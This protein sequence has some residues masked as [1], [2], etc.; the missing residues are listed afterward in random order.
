MKKSFTGPFWLL[1]G[2][3]LLLILA[4]SAYLRV[5]YGSGWNASGRSLLSTS[6]LL[7]VFMWPVIFVLEAL[8][9]WLIRQRNRYRALSW[10]HSAIFVLSFLLNIF[11]TWIRTMHYRLSSATERRIDSQIVMHEQMYFF[12]GLVILAHV[13]FVAVLANC[14]RK[15][16]PLV[17]VDPK[18]QENLLDDVIL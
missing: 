13:A 5:L 10:T 4:I 3:G 6:G 12:W 17:E 11:F 16:P 7:R 2:F 15:A 9:Y 1:M 18:S 14:F 8:V